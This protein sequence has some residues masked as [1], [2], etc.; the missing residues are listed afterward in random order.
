LENFAFGGLFKFGGLLCVRRTS[1]RSEDSASGVLLQVRR[2][3]SSSEDSACGSFTSEDLRS[4]TY[5][6]ATCDKTSQ[7]KTTQL[8]TRHSLLIDQDIATYDVVGRNA[9]QGCPNYQ[10]HFISTTPS[11]ENDV[12]STTSSSGSDLDDL[13][14]TFQ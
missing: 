14:T 11:A 9:V 12:T 5:D 13:P 3:S 4:R 6:D 8:T 1:L 10:Q 2:T 7:L